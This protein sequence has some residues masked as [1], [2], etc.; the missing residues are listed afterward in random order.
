MNKSYL[1][2][3]FG[4]S[5]VKIL[6]VCEGQV[7]ARSREAYTEPAPEGWL[8]AM[9]IALQSL[10]LTDVAAI[11]LSAQV[12]TYLINEQ[13]L[14]SWS[15]GAGRE[16]LD[17]L[18]AHYSKED[19][20]REIGFP[21]PEIISYPLPRLLYI[22]EHFPQLHSVCQPKDWVLEQLTGHRVTDP[23]SWRGFARGCSYSEY[24]LKELSIDPMWLPKLADPT[25]C[26]GFVT[27]LAADRW[28]LP[29]GIPVYTGMN[30][31]YCSLLGMGMQQPGDAFDITG[32]S[33]HLGVLEP[34][35]HPD[36]PLVSTPYMNSYVHYGVTASSGAS[37]DYAIRNFGLSAISVNPK[38]PIFLPYVNGERAPIFNSDARGVFF[39]IQG[40]CSRQDMAYAVLEGN[41]FSLYHIWETMGTPKA[42]RIIISGGA[43]QNPLLN[44]LKASLLDIPVCTL[45][46]PDTSALGAAMF[47]A[48]GSGDSLWTPKIQEIF[49]P[50]PAL[51]KLL[52]PRYAIYK[53]LYPAIKPLYN[54]W[55]ELPL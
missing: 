37:L 1:G 9:R 50:D 29:E 53:K 16:E 55:K 43:A 34:V 48:I 15:D 42:N 33:E 3:D 11:G 46:E 35:L 40:D 28:S 49:T 10:N 41:A 4:T 5:S 25:T 18:K 31:F 8:S 51:R 12:G 26:A 52:L 45:K 24:F 38:A 7:I 47:A 39:G 22:K 23:F 21:H 20:I 32:T 27:A 54:D 6:H 44:T 14:I 36:T 19:F 13:D 17:A 2:I 30:D